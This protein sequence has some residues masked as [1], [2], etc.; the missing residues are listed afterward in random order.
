L[1]KEV[2]NSLRNK[3]MRIFVTVKTRAR[4]ERVESIDASHLVVMV[5]ALPIEGRANEAVGR[6]LAQHFGVTKS[7][8]RLVSGA[9]GRHKVFEVD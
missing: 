6:L 9:S 5:K 1:R 4:E 3:D 2:R 7:Q 8:L